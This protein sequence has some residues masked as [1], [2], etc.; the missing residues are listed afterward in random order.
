MLAQGCETR[1]TPVPTTHLPAPVGSCLRHLFTHLHWQC[2]RCVQRR[3]LGDM[4]YMS[5]CAQAPRTHKNT[6]LYQQPASCM[7]ATTDGTN[8]Q[9]L[10]S[11]PSLCHDS[12]PSWPLHRCYQL[13]V[14]QGVCTTLISCCPDARVPVVAKSYPALNHTILLLLLLMSEHL[15]AYLQLPIQPNRGCMLLGADQFCTAS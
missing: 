13:T 6:L 3:L 10:R 5:G 9:L 7:A 14:S 4:W 11:S 1:A 8:Y 2:R 12:R 15:Q